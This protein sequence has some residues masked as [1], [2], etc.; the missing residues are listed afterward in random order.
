MGSPYTPTPTAL[1]GSV[2]LP[3]D[4]DPRTAASVRSQD[5]TMLD[6]IALLEDGGPVYHVEDR[7]LEW[8]PVAIDF[9]NWAVD[10]QGSL[11]DQTPGSVVPLELNFPHEA[12]VEV[13]T[14]RFDPTDGHAGLPAIM[15]T[16]KWYKLDV[17]T[18][19]ATQIG[20]TATDATATA[21]AFDAAHALSIT[22]GTPETIN[23]DLYRYIALFTS[24]SGANSA[25]GLR[26][27]SLTWTGDTVERNK[28]GA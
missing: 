23:K 8:D 1:P 21:G 6:A 4:G 27:F 26:L 14:A 5:E 19:A 25:V 28:G 24:E 3:D 13:L 2:T 10:N 17:T 16:L 18:G 9:A 20:S 12:T 15:P 7:A 22:P 11:L